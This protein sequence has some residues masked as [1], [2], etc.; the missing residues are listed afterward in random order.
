[1]ESNLKDPLMG[2]NL[3]DCVSVKRRIKRNQV[4]QATG[5][6]Y[7]LSLIPGDQ[8]FGPEVN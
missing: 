4:V 7:R 3:Q 5:F 8:L 1:M 6:L 2:Q